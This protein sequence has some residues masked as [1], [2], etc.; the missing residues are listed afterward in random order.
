M[1][2]TTLNATRQTRLLSCSTHAYDAGELEALIA[3]EIDGER[4][5]LRGT[6]PLS[7]ELL[8]RILA[9]GATEQDGGRNGNATDFAV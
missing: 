7:P 2:T 3:A 8:A 5:D 1:I 6:Q 9:A 4:R